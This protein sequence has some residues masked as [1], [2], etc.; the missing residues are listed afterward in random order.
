MS[1]NSL[2]NNLSPHVSE[3]SFFDDVKKWEK[4]YPNLRKAVNAY[5]EK[6]MLGI[7][8][9]EVREKE[10][11]TQLQLAQKAHVTQSVI[12]RIETGS[13]KTLPR[14]D[15]YNGILNAIGYQTTIVATKKG[16][17][18]LQVALT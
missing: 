16:C 18:P 1:K 2:T 5:K 17:A 14:L 3:H 13:S 12:A 4:K 11:I 6:A 9:K 15:L 8:L 10:K 7:L